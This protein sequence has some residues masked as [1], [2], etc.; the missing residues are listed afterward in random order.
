[1][2]IKTVFVRGCFRWPTLPHFLRFIVFS[3]QLCLEKGLKD[4][5]IKNGSSLCITTKELAVV[6]HLRATFADV[7]I[8][9]FQS[10]L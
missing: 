6:S 10:G 9:A 1:M 2:N 7:A 5:Q 8:S 3:L 4:N